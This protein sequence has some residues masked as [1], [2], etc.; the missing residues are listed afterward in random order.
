MSTVRSAQVPDDVDERLRQLEEDRG[1]SKS[2]AQVKAIDHGLSAMGYHPNEHRPD[3][4]L[5][6]RLRTVSNGIGTSGI[7]FIG[8]ALFGS[9]QYRLIGFGCLVLAIAVYGA[10]R[11]L[12][13]YEPALSAKIGWGPNGGERA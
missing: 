10:E 12:A 11:G 3:T 2:K 8:L 4:V 5:R 1:L 9:L 7:I 6:R 13:R